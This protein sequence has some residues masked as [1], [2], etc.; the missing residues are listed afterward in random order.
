MIGVLLFRLRM[1]ATNA[2]Q[3]GGNPS[4]IAIIAALCAFTRLTTP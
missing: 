3:S 2:G 1:P 4:Q